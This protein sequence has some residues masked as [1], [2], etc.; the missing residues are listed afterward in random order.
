MPKK[1]VNKNEKKEYQVGR[2]RSDARG[3]GGC[4][5]RTEV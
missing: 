1:E 4:R 5:D 2:R 3:F